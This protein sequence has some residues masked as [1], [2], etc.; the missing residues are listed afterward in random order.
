MEDEI[1]YLCDPDKNTV[2]RKT[3]CYL[4][5][6]CRYKEGKRCRMTANPDFAKTDEKGEKIILLRKH[7]SG[8][9]DSYFYEATEMGKNLITFP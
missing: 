3:G 6:L 8:D 9:G 4:N 1:F 7:C 5:A 2:C